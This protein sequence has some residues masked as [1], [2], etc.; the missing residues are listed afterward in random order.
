MNNFFLKPL[1]GA[2]TRAVCLT[3]RKSNANS[4]STFETACSQHKLCLVLD[5]DH[6]LLQSVMYGEL[7]PSTIDWLEKRLQ[8]TVNMPPEKKDLFKLESIQA[9]NTVDN[10]VLHQ[11]WRVV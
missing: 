6:T 8:A 10:C 3:T 5:L 7:M 11:K 1:F 2:S 4:K 9:R